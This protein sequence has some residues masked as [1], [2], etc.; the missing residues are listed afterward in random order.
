M[1]TKRILQFLHVGNFVEPYLNFSGYPGF[2]LTTHKNYDACVNYYKWL[3]GEI[4]I[5][6]K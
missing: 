1:E 5:N 3:Q 6:Y 4:S 2:I